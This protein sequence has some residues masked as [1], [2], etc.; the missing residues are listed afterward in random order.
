M[1]SKRNVERK[2]NHISVS[3]N[4]AFTDLQMVLETGN[5]SDDFFFFFFE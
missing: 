5:E 4:V 1:F 3:E 2:K